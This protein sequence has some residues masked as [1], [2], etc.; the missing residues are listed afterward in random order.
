MEETS[1]EIR[2]PGQGTGDLIQRG[3][4]CILLPWMIPGSGQF[5]SGL[6]ARGIFFFTIVA[7]MF[8]VGIA[9]DG[10]LYDFERGNLLSLFAT[11]AALGSGMWNLGARIFG[12]DANPLSPTYEYGNA[13]ILTA[14]LLNL[15]VMA[16]AWDLCGERSSEEGLEG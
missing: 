5:R 3:L 11:L 12:M 15:L 9:L 14:G 7:F 6:R 13:F 16:E 1:P 4:L 8:L 10:K 2:E